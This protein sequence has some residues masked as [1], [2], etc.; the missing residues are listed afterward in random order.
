MVANSRAIALR[1][2]TP[3]D[4]IE[5]V[6]AGAAPSHLLFIIVI[7]NGNK[8]H[9]SE[10]ARSSAPKAA[11]TTKLASQRQEIEKL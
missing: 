9:L 7:S 2:E 6:A 5:I 4:I 8:S 3:S 11:S 1:N 10:S